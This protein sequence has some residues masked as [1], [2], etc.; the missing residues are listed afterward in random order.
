MIQF[1]FNKPVRRNKI[2]VSMRNVKKNVIDWQTVNFSIFYE[3]LFMSI[4]FNPSHF[5]FTI[6]LINFK[7]GSQRLPTH[8]RDDHL[9]SCNISLCLPGRK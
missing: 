3:C 6:F 8:S 7:I 4:Y 2:L 1:F 9:K 5:V